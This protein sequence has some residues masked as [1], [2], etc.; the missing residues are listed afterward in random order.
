MSELAMRCPVC[1]GTTFLPGTEIFDDR[2]GEPN[3]YEL[4]SCAACDHVA[5][6]PRLRESDLPGLYGTYYPRK[7]ISADD[8]AREADK[9]KH[10]FA[11]LVRWWNGTDN[12]G[13]YSVRAGEALLDVGCGSGTSLLEAKELG[14][15][16]FGKF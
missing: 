8:V 11:G 14:A 6:A 10:A 2:Y 15:R 12:Q 13:Q 4:A 16:A 9:A 3:R 5:T 7:S 1:K